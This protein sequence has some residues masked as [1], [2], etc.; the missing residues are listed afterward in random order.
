MVSNSLTVCDDSSSAFIR[1]A[2]MQKEIAEAKEELVS[3]G[4]AHLLQHAL[5][6]SNLE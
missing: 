4:H 2:M 6:Y 3:A 1:C 5:E